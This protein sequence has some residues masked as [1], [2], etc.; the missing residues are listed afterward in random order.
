MYY[1]M[2]VLS[3]LELRIVCD[4]CLGC[5]DLEIGMGAK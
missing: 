2:D 5:R 4:I 1:I 3:L